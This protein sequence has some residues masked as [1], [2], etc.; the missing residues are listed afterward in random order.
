SDA[1][2]LITGGLGG[3]GLTVADWMVRQGARYLVL[4]GRSD[5]SLEAVQVI[6]TLQAM[7]AQIVTAKAD[8][9][10]E[11]QVA[12]L[13]ATIHISLPP[14]RGLIHAAAVLDD[15]VLLQQDAQ[16]FRKVMAPKIKG[17][18]N[19]HTLTARLE[20]DFFVL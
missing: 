13:L 17:A 7:G 19:L 8:I 12:D 16:R 14:L 5:A 11:Q 15:G 10:E 18:W 2:H 6:T 1:T 4:V 9:S 20:L 3:L